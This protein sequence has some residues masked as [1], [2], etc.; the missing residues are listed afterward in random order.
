MASIRL[1][2]MTRFLSAL[3]TVHKRTRAWCDASTRFD[4]PTRR[5]LC[6]RLTSPAAIEDYGTLVLEELNGMLSACTGL[7]SALTR[8]SGV[9]AILHLLPQTGAAAPHG[10]VPQHPA[11]HA[12]ELRLQRGAEADAGVTAHLVP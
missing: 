7:P 4:G 9:L 12:F 2:P 3:G 5:A 8:E 1:D 11:Q 6:E 10:E